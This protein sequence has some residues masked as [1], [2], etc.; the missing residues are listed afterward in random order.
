MLGQITLTSSAYL[1]LPE[2]RTMPV[3]YIYSTKKKEN[4]TDG[5][6]DNNS[7]SPEMDGARLTSIVT[8]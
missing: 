4:Q 5:V 6:N 1:T 8:S 3:F 2:I 7:E